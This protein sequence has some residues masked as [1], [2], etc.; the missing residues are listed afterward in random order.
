MP[1]EM[2]HHE[3]VIDAIRSSG[4]LSELLDTH[5]NH[6]KYELDLELMVYGR[7]YAEKR[8][9]PYAKLLVYDEGEEIIRE[10]D[11]GGN[12]FYILIAG[13]LDVYVKDDQGT[14]RKVGEVEV[15]NSFGEMS[16]LAGQPRNAT[17]VVTK[18]RRQLISKSNGQR[19]A[20]CAN[21]RNSE[22]D[23]NTIIG[24]MD[25]TTRCCKSRRLRT[26]LSTP[27]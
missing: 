23:L 14:N 12:T 9:G 7:P 1:R 19:F 22:I 18:A 25:L 16:V 17:V 27:N 6:F 13:R 3:A 24:N 2:A 8:V 15:Q 11:W 26:T 20:S 4:L 10:G 5:D 21:S